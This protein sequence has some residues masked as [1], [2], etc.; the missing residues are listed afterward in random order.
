MN[1]HTL[2][3][4]APGILLALT[5]HEFAHGWVAYRLGDPTA[6]DQGRLTLNPLAHLDLIG[7]IMLFIVHFGW[8]RPVP[9]NPSY[10]QNPLRGMVWVAL[11]GP[12]SNVVLALLLGLTLQSLMG[13]GLVGSFSFTYMLLT[14][15]VFINL[16]LAFFNLIPIPPLDGSKIVGG[17]LP[18]RFQDAW[19]RF[20]QFGFIILIGLI[21]MGSFLGIHVLSNTI[22]PLSG[23][24]YQMFTG[25]LPLRL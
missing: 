7:T 25:G 20:E 4:L 13:M 3:L 10:F 8:A 6:R 14:Y 18:L 16:M 2:I 12:A 15:A 21:F 22:F 1:F 9:V 5:V 17:L 11:A 24:F 23:I 19:A